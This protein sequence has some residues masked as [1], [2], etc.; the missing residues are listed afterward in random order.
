MEY[1]RYLPPG[2][3][4]SYVRYFWSYHSMK[5]N[6]SKLRI[7]SFAD[8]FPRLIFQDLKDFEALQTTTNTLLPA[9]YISGVDTLP[10]TSVMDGR[11][12]HF[13]ISFYPHALH[14]LFKI[15]ASELVNRM[16][17][18][19]LIVKSGLAQKLNDT[20]SDEERIDLVSRFLID[21]LPISKRTNQLINNIIHSEHLSFD[22]SVISLQEEFKVSERQLER[23]FKSAIGISPKKYQ[24]ILRFESALEKLSAANYSDL[25]AISYDL[26]FSDQAHFINDFKNLSGLSP[27][28]FVKNNKIG[29]ESSS[30]IT[31]LPSKI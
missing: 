16:P 14:T 31:V 26:N 2:E 15:D 9:C 18:I 25:T 7:E 21:S 10:S 5:S 19:E 30:F 28:E 23:V 20:V 13:G 1:K 24:R 6:A 27:Y 3:L 11:F 12:S 29:S 17:D 8:R 22:A 4:K